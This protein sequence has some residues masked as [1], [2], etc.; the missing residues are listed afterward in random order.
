MSF[1][2]DDYLPGDPLPINTEEEWIS[3]LKLSSAWEMEKVRK[4]SID[5]LSKLPIPPTKKIKHGRDQ[6]PVEDLAKELGWEITAKIL[7]IRGEMQA[8]GNFVVDMS[9]L[10]CYM[11]GCSEQLHL[12]QVSCEKGH[13]VR[14]TVSDWH[15]G[16]QKK[17]LKMEGKVNGAALRP[18]KPKANE[19]KEQIE[20][21]FAVGG[22]TTV[23]D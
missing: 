1:S 16:N 19:W 6:Y 3:V 8:A 20:K 10:T 2:S 4:M 21:T 9:Q 22:S 15:G 11:F 14:I 12:D 17:I 13:N 18:M 7:W 23:L 5:H